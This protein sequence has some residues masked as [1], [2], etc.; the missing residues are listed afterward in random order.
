MR[1][2]ALG[3]FPPEVSHG[4]GASSRTTV[5]IGMMMMMMMKLM[6]KLMMKMMMMPNMMTMIC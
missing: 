3:A 1:Q 5:A 4:G 6:M 2:R